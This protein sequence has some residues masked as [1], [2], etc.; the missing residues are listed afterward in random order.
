M[1]R[2]EFITLLGG[3][4][5]AWPIAARAQNIYGAILVIGGSLIVWGGPIL[6]A[7][8]VLWGNNA[9]RR[10]ATRYPGR[11]RDTR[12]LVHEVRAVKSLCRVRR[13]LSVACQGRTRLGVSRREDCRKASRLAQS[14]VIRRAR[15]D[16]LLRT[17]WTVVGDER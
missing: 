9:K 15:L 2:R 6:L 1:H 17:V 12:Q 5:V 7:I 8:L 16:V 11:Q 3:A 13:F 14:A 10:T 4:A